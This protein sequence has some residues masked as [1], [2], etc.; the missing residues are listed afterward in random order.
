MRGGIYALPI[1]LFHHG[2]VGAH[3][4]EDIERIVAG[5]RAGLQKVRKG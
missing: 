3:D 2:L 1:P 5:M 4:R